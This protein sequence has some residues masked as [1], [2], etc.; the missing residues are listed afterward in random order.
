MVV[1]VITPVVAE[2]A[3]AVVA[4]AAVAAVAVDVPR[5]A[6]AKVSSQ[7]ARKARAQMVNAAVALQ[8][9]WDRRS[10]KQSR[11]AGGENAMFRSMLTLT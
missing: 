1:S 10:V 3:V 5:R 8:H 4:T 6:M 7:G 2:V 9:A 11:R